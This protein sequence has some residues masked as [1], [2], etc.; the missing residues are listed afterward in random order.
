MLTLTACFVVS[1]FESAL[2]LLFVSLRRVV[3]DDFVVVVDAV[4]VGLTMFVV[5]VEFVDAEDGCCCCCCSSISVNTL[6]LGE[7]LYIFE[8]NRIYQLFTVLI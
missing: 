7:N 6:N 5:D 8:M 4:D 2:L 1:A 3:I